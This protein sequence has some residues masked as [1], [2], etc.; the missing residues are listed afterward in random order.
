MRVEAR[1]PFQ[2]AV[3]P[4]LQHQRGPGPALPVLEA[5][6]RLLLRL[7]APAAD[8]SPAAAHRLFV[9]NAVPRLAQVLHAD[10]RLSMRIWR[11]QC[12]VRTIERK[13]VAPKGRVASV[14]GTAH[15]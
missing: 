5:G 7:A 11:C 9:L 4:A 8:G 6:L 3:R 2:H 10:V 15:T 1:V 12:I 14:I 13:R